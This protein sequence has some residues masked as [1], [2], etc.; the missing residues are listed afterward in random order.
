M[1]NPAALYMFLYLLLTPPDTC[2]RVVHY[3]VLTK[4]FVPTVAGF[5]KALL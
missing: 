4:V 5:I 2:T 1:G 3:I